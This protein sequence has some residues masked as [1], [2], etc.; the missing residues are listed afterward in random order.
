MNQFSSLTEDEDK[1]NLQKNPNVA[2]TNHTLS[3]KIPC[4][5]YHNSQNMPK[6]N[7][8]DEHFPGKSAQNQTSASSFNAKKNNLNKLKKAVMQETT[9]DLCSCIKFAC[10]TYEKEILNDE[11]EQLLKHID[12]FPLMPLKND[13][14]IKVTVSALF[15]VL[16][17]GHVQKFMHMRERRV[18]SSEIQKHLLDFVKRAIKEKLP[19]TF[20]EIDMFNEILNTIEKQN[21]SELDIANIEYEIDTILNDIFKRKMINGNILPFEAK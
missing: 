6:H 19:K 3:G 20:F 21:L 4:H 16:L 17:N 11:T 8:N 18:S 5:I 1:K 9:E 15:E 13:T 7:K 2:I 10:D 14:K 12:N